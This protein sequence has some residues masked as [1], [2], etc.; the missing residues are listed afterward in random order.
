MFRDLVRIDKHIS[1]N[2]G[3]GKVVQAEEKGNTNILAYYGFECGEKHL[4]EVLYIPSFKDNLFSISSMLDTNL[5]YTFN[6]TNNK[7]TFLWSAK[8][9]AMGNREGNLFPPILHVTTLN[10][11]QS[12]DREHIENTESA[13]IGQSKMQTLREWHEKMVHQNYTHVIKLLGHKGIET[14]GDEEPYHPCTQPPGV[15]SRLQIY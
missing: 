11:Q 3:D 8:V 14:L 10:R 5:G 6:L 15:Y 2:L 12:A 7:C 1:I 9:E 13:L 4:E